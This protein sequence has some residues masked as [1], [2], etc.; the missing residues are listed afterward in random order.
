MVKLRRL[1]LLLGVCSISN[2]SDLLHQILDEAQ[3]NTK[4]NL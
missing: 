3:N 1:E 2:H 4:T